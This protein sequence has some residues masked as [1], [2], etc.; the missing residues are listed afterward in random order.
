MKIKKKHRNSLKN[1]NIGKNRPKKKK[2]KNTDNV[3]PLKFDY[4][5]VFSKY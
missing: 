2:K 5:S 1:K 3:L 4:G